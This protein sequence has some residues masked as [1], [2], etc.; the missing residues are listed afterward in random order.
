MFRKGSVGVPHGKGLQTLSDA[1][2]RAGKGGFSSRAGLHYM[3]KCGVQDQRLL[4]S[5]QHEDEF[6]FSRARVFVK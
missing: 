6:H 4:L 2:I 1:E 5:N 3:N